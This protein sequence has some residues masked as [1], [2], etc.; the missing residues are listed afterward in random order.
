[1]QNF[2]HPWTA[3]RHFTN[4]RSTAIKDVTGRDPIAFDQFAR[5]YANAWMK[6][7]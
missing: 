4:A 2:V 6:S 3:W 5:D 7:K 1:M